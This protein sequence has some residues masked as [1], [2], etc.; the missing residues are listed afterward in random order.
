MGGNYTKTVSC[1]KDNDENVLCIFLT[2]GRNLLKI[3]TDALVYLT[4]CVSKRLDPA[5]NSYAA[6][7]LGDDL[8]I[9]RQ[10]TRWARAI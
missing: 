10:A 1:S 8:N 2:Q 7:K 6:K 3:D 5:K 9:L 4:S